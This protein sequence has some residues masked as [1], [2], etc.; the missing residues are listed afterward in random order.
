MPLVNPYITYPKDRRRIHKLRDI[1]DKF[2]QGG[3][4]DFP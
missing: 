2:C 3:S 4:G 1:H